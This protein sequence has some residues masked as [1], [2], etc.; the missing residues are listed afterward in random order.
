MSGRHVN[1]HHHLHTR[2]I[3]T[4]E[5]KD[6][7]ALI[8]A[9]HSIHGGEG[10]YLL[11]TSVATRMRT[12][13]DLNF[14]SDASLPRWTNTHTH[15]LIIPLQLDQLEG[16]HTTLLFARMINVDGRGEVRP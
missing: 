1:V 6:T 10:G 14:A 2:D 13:P 12:W 9:H 15:T 3:Q 11:A 8:G 7:T 16:S 5:E 4:P